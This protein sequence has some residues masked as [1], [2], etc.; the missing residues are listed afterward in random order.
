MAGFK[1]VPPRGKK[2][3]THAEHTQYLD[4]LA[5]PNDCKAAWDMLKDEL[6]NAPILMHPDFTKGFIL[7]CDSSKE[8]RYGAA[9]HQKDNE[10]IERP[11]LY[12]SKVLDKYERNNWSTKL[13]V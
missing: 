5:L 9:L 3:Q 10:G 8:C 7:Y 12:L 1:S 13:E 6:Y 4:D 11:I 2:R